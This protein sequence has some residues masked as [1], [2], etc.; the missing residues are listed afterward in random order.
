MSLGGS[1]HWFSFAHYLQRPAA[2]THSVRP[3]FVQASRLEPHPATI[4]ALQWPR[5]DIQFPLAATAA[6]QPA[7]QLLLPV[8]WSENLPWSN[9]PEPNRRCGPLHKRTPKNCSVPLPAC[10]RRNE[11]RG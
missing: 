8:R 2:P 3:R 1:S 6:T 7:T 9:P 4:P 10:A 5:L 11:S